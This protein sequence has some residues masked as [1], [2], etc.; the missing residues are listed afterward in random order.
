MKLS[1]AAF[2]SLTAGLATVVLTSTAAGAAGFG[3]HWKFDESGTPKTAADSS[4]NGNTGT[5]H[6]IKGTGE[7]YE[8]NGNNS[9]VVAPDDASLD[10]GSADFTMT[11]T[12]I[13]DT[14]AGGK[15]YDLVRKGLS[16]TN[17]GEYKLEII[18]VNGQARALC[19]VK[20]SNKVVASIR[21]TTSL[22]DGKA[23]TLTCTK[24]STG[25][26]LNSGSGAVRTKRVTRLGSISNSAALVIGAKTPSGGD[27]FFSGKMTDLALTS[28]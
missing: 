18:N 24:T 9:W 25:V 1:S 27:D 20:D 2:G 15:D 19:L 3:A 14:P 4:G 13:T 10:P 28:G 26:T 8:F 23:H 22:D 21:G 6:N 11:V 17:G 7:G 16:G 5:N 12:V